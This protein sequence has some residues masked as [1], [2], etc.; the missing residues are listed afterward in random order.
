[1]FLNQLCEGVKQRTN[2][3]RYSN[4]RAFFNFIRGNIDNDF[5]NPCDTAMIMRIFRHPESIHWDIIE[6]EVVDEVI[7]RTINPRNRLDPGKDLW[8]KLCW[9]MCRLMT[10]KEGLLRYVR[11]P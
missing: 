7:F 11:I 3:S 9:R 10:F 2:R 6:K 1:M 4:L 8:D 5:I